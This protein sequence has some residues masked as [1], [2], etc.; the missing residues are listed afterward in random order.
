M[1]APTPTLPL[2]LPL[3]CEHCGGD[4]CGW[5]DGG[6]KA[7][8][9]GCPMEELGDDDWAGWRMYLLFKRG[10]MPMPGGALQQT[11]QALEA[12]AVFADA[13]NTVRAELKMDP[14]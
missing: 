3:P 11:R 4:G 7:L 9:R 14:E 5:C 1:N 12:F 2:V 13:E 8:V 10:L 6:G